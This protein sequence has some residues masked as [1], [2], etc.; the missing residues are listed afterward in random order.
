M[1]RKAINPWEWSMQ[2]GF[3]QGELIE[4]HRRMLICSGQ[5]AMSAE[6]APQHA[7][8]LRSQISLALDNLEAVLADAGM[9]LSNIVRLNIYTTDV[10]ALL[11]NHGVL[12][13]RLGRA[14]VMPPVTLLGVSRLAFPELL[15]ELEATA[16]D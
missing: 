13:E 2:F 1:N 6:G 8:N 10:D 4:G 5:T 12:A 9:T 14:N 11:E 15:V 3:N 7:G 16:A